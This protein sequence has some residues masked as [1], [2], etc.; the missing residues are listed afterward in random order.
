MI[1]SASKVTVARRGG[2]GQGR[3]DGKTI[4]GSGGNII[5]GVVGTGPPMIVTV[6]TETVTKGA[7]ADNT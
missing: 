3:H 1:A 6:G 5:P 2:P 7:G 4:V